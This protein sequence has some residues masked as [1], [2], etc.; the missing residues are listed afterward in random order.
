LLHL[1]T[2]TKEVAKI[3][4]KQLRKHLDTM[5]LLFRPRRMLGEAV[6]GAERESAGGSERTIAEFRELYRRVAVRPFDL[7]P[8]LTFPLESVSTQLQLY[9]WEYLHNTKTD[10]GWRSI[11]VTSPL[12]WVIAYSS[13]YSLSMLR[14]ALAG[15]EERDPEAVRAFVLRACIMHTH[16][17]KFPAIADL[18]AGLRYRVEV[19][20]SPELGELPLVTLSPPFSTVRPPDNLVTVASVSP[21]APVSP[22]CW[23]SR[24][25]ATCEIP[26][27]TR[28][29]PCL[30][31]TGRNS[32]YHEK[33]APRCLDEGDV[34][35]AATLPD[36]G[37]I[38]RERSPIPVR[39]F[40]L[41]KL[42]CDRAGHRFRSPRKRAVP[43]QHLRRNHARWR[44]VRYS[45]DRR[46]APSRSVVEHFPP[47]RDSLDV[48]SDSRNPPAR[49]QCDDSG[50]GSGERVGPPPNTRYLAETRMVTDDNAGGEEKPVQV[51][52]RT[53]RLL[54]EGEYATGSPPS[55]SR[56]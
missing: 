6:E 36:A 10:R 52:A 8:E 49:T 54:F 17:T 24:P 15:Q 28:S 16:F 43:S 37:S 19:R 30:A 31:A 12:T 4:Q 29:R 13:T 34:S 18:L 51:A 32:S 2:L 27:A 56:R 3:C 50:I 38:L 41:C 42:G 7:R 5:A 33:Q 14:Q 22:R 39:R 48:F 40:A 1:H 35:H 44:T 25:C 9:E 21:V 26:F 23:I 11:R 20:R 45:R 46:H 55:A 53:F 47:T